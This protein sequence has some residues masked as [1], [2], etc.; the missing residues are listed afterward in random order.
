MIQ[1]NYP[2][3]TDLRDERIRDIEDGYLFDTMTNGLRNMPAFGSQVPVADRW[4]IIAYIR[5]LG[6]T[7]IGTSADL[8]AEV[9]QRFE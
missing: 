6:R 4:A 2:P 1:Y 8:P 7:Q 3:P 9:R 5:A